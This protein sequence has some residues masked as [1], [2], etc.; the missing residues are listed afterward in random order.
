MDEDC[1]ETYKFCQRFVVAHMIEK[2]GRECSGATPGLETKVTLLASAGI[3]TYG[4]DK[5]ADDGEEF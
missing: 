3:N 2:I 5:E 4:E 1:P